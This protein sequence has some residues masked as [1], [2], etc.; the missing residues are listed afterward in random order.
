M[1][2]YP[3]PYEEFNLRTIANLKQTFGTVVGLSDHSLG[4]AVAIAAVALGA[5]VVEKHFTIKLS[6]GGSDALFSMEAPEFKAMVE[7]IRHAE[8]TLGQ[9]T[10]KLSPKQ[11]RSRD[12]SRSLYIVKDVKKGEVLTPENLR[13]IRPGF[14]LHTKY[15]DQLLGKKV[16]CDLPKGTAMAWK[17]VSFD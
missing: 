8:A 9:V 5:R 10:Y 13:S 15:Y 1:S 4:D 7:N 17:Y 16:N 12:S 2:A 14:G 11:I 6:D 3:T